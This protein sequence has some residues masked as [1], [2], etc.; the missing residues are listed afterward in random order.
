[1]NFKYGV[2]GLDPPLQNKKEAYN[3]IRQWL[4]KFLSETLVLSSTVSS[5]APQFY[6]VILVDQEHREDSYCYQIMAKQSQYQE[7]DGSSKLMTKI[8]LRLVGGGGASMR[9]TG[10]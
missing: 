8:R 7:P 5:G 3:T 1:M 10:T 4:V 6:N 9:S 2:H